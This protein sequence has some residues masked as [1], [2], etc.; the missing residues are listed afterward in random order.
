MY[1]IS[2]LYRYIYFGYFLICSLL[3]FVNAIN[4]LYMSHL[5]SL[6]ISNGLTVPIITHF[7]IGLTVMIICQ[8]IAYYILQVDAATRITRNIANEAMEYLLKVQFKHLDNPAA[9]V[10]KIGFLTAANGIL[11][12]IASDIIPV[13]LAVTGM[14]II[15]W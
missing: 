8:R 11:S 3:I 5:M 13:S 7:I 2:Y 14:I 12:F 10:A 6:I 15:M 4:I 9:K 1:L